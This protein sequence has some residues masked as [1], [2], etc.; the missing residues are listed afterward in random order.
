MRFLFGCFTR[1]QN[2]PPHHHHPTDN[3]Q[4]QHMQQQ[5]LVKS[6]LITN[7]KYRGDK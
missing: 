6:Q 1:R 3:V 5:N 2:D 4:Q 7:A